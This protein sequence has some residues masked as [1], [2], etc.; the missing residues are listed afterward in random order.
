MVTIFGASQSLWRTV[1]KS[2]P[3]SC[4]RRIDTPPRTRPPTSPSRANSLSSSLPLQ[5]ARAPLDR[6]TYRSRDDVRAW[7]PWG[8]YVKR[9]KMNRGLCV[10]VYNREVCEKGS[11]CTARHSMLIAE[12]QTSSDFKPGAVRMLLSK[13]HRP[14]PEAVLTLWDDLE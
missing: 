14:A 8:R 12:E 9:D 11:Q 7:I 3:E 4:T 6:C 13:Y 10:F 5:G 2:S 1:S